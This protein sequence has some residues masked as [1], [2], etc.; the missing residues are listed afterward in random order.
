MLV[1]V[2]TNLDP[3][4]AYIRNWYARYAAP[5]PEELLAKVFSL[6]R[7]SVRTYLAEYENLGL[8]HLVPDSAGSLNVTLTE[9]RRAAAAR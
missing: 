3:I 9:A 4:L 1:L 7:D 8:V 6:T 2:R 5:C